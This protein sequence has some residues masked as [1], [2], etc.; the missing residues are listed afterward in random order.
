[1]PKILSV[2]LMLL[3]TPMA[4]SAPLYKTVTQNGQ[5]VY[6]DN[7]NYAYQRNQ[8]PKQIIVIDNLSSRSNQE[9]INN[10]T[11]FDFEPM[12]ISSTS[13]SK[14]G[15]YQL[16]INSPTSETLYRRPFQNIEINISINPTLQPSDSVVYKLN[17]KEIFRGKAMN[18]STATVDI[19]PDKYI[20]TVQVVNA[21]NQI[22]AENKTNI[23]VL[24]NNTLIQKQ[25]KLK[26]EKDAYDALPWYKKMSIRLNTQRE[27]HNK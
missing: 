15:D 8:D 19:N 4:F 25:R 21:Q 3:I 5:I 2:S 22:I 17:D 16:T 14:K 23:Y 1:M 12:N 6:T 11:S 10:T 7:I 18:Y 24:Q 27:K 26:A 9:N 13:V 20:L